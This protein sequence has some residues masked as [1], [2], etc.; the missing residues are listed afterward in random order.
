MFDTQLTKILDELLSLLPLNAVEHDNLR[1]QMK[2]RIVT[3][4]Y[5]LLTNKPLT[6]DQRSRE[7]ETLSQLPEDDINTTLGTNPQNTLKALMTALGS[8]AADVFAQ[9]KTQLTDKQKEEIK[10][11]LNAMLQ[12]NS[13]FP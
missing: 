11:K 5:L 6:P 12:K 10:N 2:L 4:T 13:L 3:D 7:L 9:A 1:N 8:T